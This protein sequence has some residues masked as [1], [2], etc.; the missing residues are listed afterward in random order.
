[1]ASSSVREGFDRIAGE[2]DALKVCVIPGYREV[3]ALVDRY[4]A[5]PEG[6]P[7]RVLELGLGTGEWAERF[8]TRHPEVEFEGVD[9]SDR[10]RS[11]AGRR[12]E[13]FRD[14]VRLHAT[15]LNDRLPR[16]SFDLVVSFFALHHVREKR[17][18]VA[19][20][21]RRLVEGGRFL[22]A[23]ITTADTPALEQLFL[24]DWVAFMRQSG[25]EDGEVSHV[26]RDH[27]ENDLAEP[28]DRQLGYMRRAAFDPA[29]V[30][31]SHGKFVLFF[32]RRSS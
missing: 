6:A 14:N 20:V 13:P 2:Y 4:A 24:D 8:L 11:I 10:M 15:D 31:W 1:M 25:L 30:V 12:L 29:A 23:D 3:Q 18:L 21:S 32:G 26:L 27:R 5:V 9:F 7:A 28:V 19:E 16:G 17:R 22:W